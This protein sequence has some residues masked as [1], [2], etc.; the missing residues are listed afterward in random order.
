MPLQLWSKKPKVNYHTSISWIQYGN[1][2]LTTFHKNATI[3]FK[4]QNGY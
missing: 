4:R 1:I 3:I 2:I